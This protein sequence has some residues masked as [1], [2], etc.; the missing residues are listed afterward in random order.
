MLYLMGR[1]PEWAC[2]GLPIAGRLRR[3]GLIRNHDKV[4]VFSSRLRS[5][6]VDLL[7]LTI[8]D[9]SR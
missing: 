6:E 3:W 4:R 7:F 5:L 2:R 8:R 1:M 9:G